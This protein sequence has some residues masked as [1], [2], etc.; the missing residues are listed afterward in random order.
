VLTRQGGWP[1]S[2]FLTPQLEPFYGG[3]YFP[4]T[5]MYGRPGFLTL[6]RAIEEAYRQRRDDVRTST[7]QLVQVL[8]QLAEP[9]RPVRPITVD[10]HWVEELLDRTIADYDPAH[11]GFGRAPKFPRETELELILSMNTIAPSDHRMQRLAHTLDAMADGGI[12]DQ[13]GGG[14]HRYSTDAH[15]LVPHFEIMLYDNAMLGWVYAE[16]SKQFNEP[17]YAKVARGVFD[18]ILREMMAP[19]GA[20]YTAFDAEVDAM[21]GESYLWT[22]EEITQLLGP[23][24]ARLFNRIY[25]VD[26]GPNFSDPH[27]GSGQPEKNILFLPNSLDRV[28]AGM[29]VTVDQL[30]AKL[31]PMRQ[32]L[33][34]ARLRRKQPLLDTKVLTSWNAL[35]IRG[36][37]HAGIVLNEPRYVDAAA[38][39]A[40]FLLDHHRGPDGRL[41]RTSREGSP[42]KFDAFLDDY[43]F[44]ADGLLA[45]HAAQPDAGWRAEVEM[46]ADAMVREFAAAASA[47]YYTAAGA[48]DLIVRQMV[49][50]DSPLPSGNGVAARA[51]LAIGRPEVARNVLSA[52]AQSLE[53]QAEGMS[54]LVQAAG[55]YVRDHGPLDVTSGPSQARPGSPRE[56]AERA[57]TVRTRWTG[58]RELAVELTIEEGFHVNANPAGEGLIATALSLPGAEV[59][60]PVAERRQ[61]PFA[62][63][64]L[65]VYEGTVTLRATFTGQMEDRVIGSI[66]YQPCT[67]DACLAPVTKAL[68]I[69]APV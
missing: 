27:H 57:V 53:D 52:F 2:V 38:K 21:E 35:T 15:W 24:D 11:G 32:A 34:Q 23:G 45:L 3:T 5:D 22:A 6:I 40:R 41:M 42:A 67:G 7:T 28:A 63:E 30:D 20:F 68:M 16:A 39:A 14:F 17:R 46:L 18:F 19:N 66:T 31:E 51:M 26:R 69:E 13:L 58:P 4:P 9:R 61:F 33:Y 29:G 49:G 37:A 56:R 59:T 50:T 8:R 25:G 43:A 62:P 64:A 44:L 10:A 55:L 36:L 65:P 60:Y 48:Q 1:M 47:F 54:A 12:R